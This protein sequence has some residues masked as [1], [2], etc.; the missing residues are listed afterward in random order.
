MI[1]KPKN[2]DSYEWFNILKNWFES[3]LPSGWSFTDVEANEIFIQFG[4]YS[5]GFKVIKLLECDLTKE[6]VLR[7]IELGITRK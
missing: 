5:T 1:I 4:N 6:N 3:F 2:I 7:M